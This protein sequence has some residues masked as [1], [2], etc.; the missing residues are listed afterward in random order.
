MPIFEYRCKECKHLFSTLVGVVAD[1][2][3]IQ[4]PKCSG[5]VVDK[6]FSRFSAPRDESDGDMDQ[7]MQSMQDEAGDDM[8]CEGC[9]SQCP[10]AF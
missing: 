4:C 6:Q 5:T 3:A 8:P 2:P 9:P 10:N 1:G 7:M